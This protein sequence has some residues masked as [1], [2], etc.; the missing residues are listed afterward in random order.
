MPMVRF[1]GVSKSYPG[2]KEALK[3]VSFELARGE[4]A[5]LTGTVAPV[6]VP[7]SN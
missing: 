4:F 3:Q 7:C 6:K 1:D 5:F 2:G